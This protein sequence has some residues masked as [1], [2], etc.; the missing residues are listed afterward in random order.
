MYTLNFYLKK[1]FQAIAGFSRVSGASFVGGSAALSVSR[2]CQVLAFF[3]PLKIFIV[4]NSGDIPEYFSFFPESMEYDDIIISLSVLVPVIYFLFITMGIVSRWLLD[5]HLKRFDGQT[6]TIGSETA[7]WKKVKKLHGRM[8]KVLSDMG[9]IVAS[10]VFVSVLDPMVGAV[11]VVL[12][13]FNL[14]LFNAKAFSSKDKDRLTFLKLHRRQ[15]IEYISSANFLIIFAVLAVQLI[16]FDMTIYSAIFM[17]LV[18]RMV[19]Q[20]LS[21]FSMESLY[22]IKLLP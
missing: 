12:L 1:L 20:A 9:L 15:F 14:L 18:S 13:Y 6:L 17:L 21:R 11:L 2:V 7:R 19:F 22:L 16:F 3:L 5:V 10:V 4:I 8:A